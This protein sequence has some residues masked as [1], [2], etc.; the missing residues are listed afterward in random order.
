MTIRNPNCPP[1]CAGVIPGERFVTGRDCARCWHWANTPAYRDAAGGR[2]PDSPP[3]KTTPAPCRYRSEDELTI[4]EKAE[5][6]KDRSKVWHWCRGPGGKAPRGQAVCSCQGCGPVC[7]GYSPGEPGQDA[8]DVIVQVSPPRRPLP[9]PPPSTARPGPGQLPGKATAAAKPLRWSYGVTTCAKRVTDLLPAAVQSLAAAGF[10][11]PHLFVDGV[12]PQHWNAGVIPEPV[13]RLNCTLRYPAVR[14]VGN[15]Y[16]A[17]VDLYYRDP[18]ADRY[19]LFQDDLEASAGVRAY[20]DAC[21]WPGKAYLNLYTVPENTPAGLRAMNYPCHVPDGFEGWYPSNQR[22]RGAVALV[23]DP[24]AMLTLLSAPHFV[25][26]A[27]NRCREDRAESYPHH[28]LDGGI[29]E[30]M[31]QAG[32]TEYV[33]S[34]SL[35]QHLG[36][37]SSMGSRPQPSAADYRGPAFDAMTLAVR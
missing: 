37:E 18:R 17:L 34:P 35:V 28:N 24:E 3:Q 8:G 13:R 33:H 26:R 6:H 21:P 31:T 2:Y 27:K 36:R 20:L 12:H 7:S 19:A 9:V 16:A 32:F 15:W 10:G 1:V 11:E 5:H 14:T 30:A 22:G 29:V 25:R 4:A 23:F